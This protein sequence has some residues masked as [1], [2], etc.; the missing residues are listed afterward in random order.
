MGNKEAVAS[1]IVGWARTT[2]VLD[3]D[4]DNQRERTADK[5]YTWVSKW[6]KI[7]FISEQMKKSL[8]WF[9]DKIDFP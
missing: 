5:G 3:S 4:M 7:I 8:A 2:G 6:T 1:S 9:L